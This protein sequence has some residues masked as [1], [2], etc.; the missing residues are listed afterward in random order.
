MKK[1]ASKLCFC[2]FFSYCLD[3]R[4]LSGM[5]F[6]HLH[7]RLM[8]SLCS[9]FT[10]KSKF[11]DMDETSKQSKWLILCLVNCQN[12]TK[13]VS[14]LEFSVCICYVRLLSGQNSHNHPIFTSKNWQSKFELLEQSEWFRLLDQIVPRTQIRDKKVI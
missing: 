13:F 14:V 8:L 7:N 12:G 2:Y 11:E 9:S 10:C 6:N 1:N 5:P 4:S 3:K